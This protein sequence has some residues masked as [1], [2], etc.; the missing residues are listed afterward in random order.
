MW[1]DNL[2]KYIFLTK[3]TQGIIYL[4][5]YSNLSDIS[6]VEVLHVSLQISINFFKINMLSWLIIELVHLN[7]VPS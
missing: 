2:Y 7:T 6:I 5:N 4:I 1:V 3:E